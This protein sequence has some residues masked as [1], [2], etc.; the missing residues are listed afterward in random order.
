MFYFSHIHMFPTVF[1]FIH[2]K[3][4]R[5]SVMCLSRYPVGGFINDITV[6][7]LCTGI[8]A[9]VSASH[10]ATLIAL[11]Y[12]EI[13]NRRIYLGLSKW[14]KSVYISPYHTFRIAPPS[15]AKFIYR[16][17]KSI[18]FFTRGPAPYKSRE[19]YCTLP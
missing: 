2:S 18:L 19:L 10:L 7:L 5:M 4:N 13:D 8:S 3:S 17:Y 12:N 14:N 9:G 6:V 1:S 16:Y 15:L 11:Y